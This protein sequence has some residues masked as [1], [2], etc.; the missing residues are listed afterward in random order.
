M[1]GPPQSCRRHFGIAP[2]EFARP[3]MLSRR[4]PLRLHFLPMV[5]LLHVDPPRR[6]RDPD[7]RR[8]PEAPLDPVDRFSEVIFGLIMVLAFTGSLSVVGGG[9]QD[10]HTMLVAALTCNLAWG[11][12][13]GVMYVLTSVAERARRVAVFLGI[14]AADPALARSLVLSALPEAFEA[15]T[16]DDAAEWIAARIRA[17]LEPG[18]RSPVTGDDLRGGLWSGVLV[19]L[20]TLPRPFR[21]CSSPMPSV[22]SGSRRGRRGQPLP[23]GLLA[24]TRNRHPGLAARPRDGRPRRRTRGGHDRAGWMI[25][26]ADPSPSSKTAFTTFLRTARSSAAWSFSFWSA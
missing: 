1:H 22:R 26:A 13:D 5:I 11:L 25:P 16:D 14:R 20:A 6:P 3:V 15:I 12:V 9:E 2:D 23:R 4:R 24:G 7:R 18:P 8:V 19:V 21:S 17:Q 10:V